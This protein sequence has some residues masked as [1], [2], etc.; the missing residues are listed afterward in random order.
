MFPLVR[1]CEHVL[2]AS[3][4][5]V[6]EAPDHRQPWSSAPRVQRHVA[7]QRGPRVRWV[8]AGH[9]PR[10]RV[11]RARPA[12]PALR[13]RLP[14]Q[15]MKW[16]LGSEGTARVYARARSIGIK[17]PLYVNVTNLQEVIICENHRTKLSEFPAKI[18]GPN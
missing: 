5:R 16:I 3:G 1:G 14:D 15:V 10:D 13:V 11:S 7:V 8:R 12:P 17:R 9:V 18:I 4:Q 2:V 6:A